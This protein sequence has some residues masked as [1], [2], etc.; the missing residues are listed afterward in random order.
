MDMKVSR[1][2]LPRPV[3]TC[4]D[5]LDRRIIAIIQ[6][7]L[8]LSSKPYQEIGNRLGI[9]EE[10]VIARIKK[11]V[12]DGV[13]K[14]FGI[15]VRHHELGYRAN[16]M[17]VWDIPDEHV[18]ELGVCMGNFDFVTL[19]YQRPRRLPQW[20]YNLF[21]MIHGQDRD[22]VLE[23]IDLLIKRCSLE[24]IQHD[25]LFSTKRYKQRGAVY[26]RHCNGG[27]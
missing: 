24:S 14:R 20:P 18:S 19:C 22:H 6:A 25:V 23:N 2:V 17:T 10:E 5:E 27:D 21:A 4:L 11:F 8:P 16:A 1:R 3:Y 12:D 13:I 7:G 9:T 26:Q 15:V